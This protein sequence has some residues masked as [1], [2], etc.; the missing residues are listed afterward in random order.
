MTKELD[1][2]DRRVA[3]WKF[4]SN[5]A[6]RGQTKKD[7][8]TIQSRSCWTQKTSFRDFNYIPW[9]TKNNYAQIV[10]FFHAFDRKYVEWVFFSWRDGNVAFVFSS[11][12]F[13]FYLL[14][15]L[16]CSPSFLFFNLKNLKKIL[17]T[18]DSNNNLNNSKNITKNEKHLLY[19][20]DPM[21]WR[22]ILMFSTH[23]NTIL[24]LH[25]RKTN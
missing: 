7:R 22:V 17:R 14:P 3:N 15:A 25:Q 2:F 5:K 20:C 16:H 18:I 11:R 8:W 21:S 12:V 6:S 10:A 1:I 13:L 23:D 4:Q 24:F 19:L 9:T